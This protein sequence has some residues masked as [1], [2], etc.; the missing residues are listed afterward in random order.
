MRLPASQNDIRKPEMNRT[1]GQFHHSTKIAAETPVVRPKI[2]VS[3]KPSRPVIKPVT[4]SVYVPEPSAEDL[5]L[6]EYKDAAHRLGADEAIK[7]FI[8]KYLAKK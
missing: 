2:N 8:A 6:T 4:K 7:E 5:A 1:P 3:R